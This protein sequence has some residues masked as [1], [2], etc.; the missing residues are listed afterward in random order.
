MTPRAWLAGVI[1][2][3]RRRRMWRRE[4]AR[5][6]LEAERR[7]VQYERERREGWHRVGEP[8][9]RMRPWVRRREETWRW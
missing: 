9:A 8:P 7:Q 3:Y 6:R 4:E 5:N 2:A 1:A